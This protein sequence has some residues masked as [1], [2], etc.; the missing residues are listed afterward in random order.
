MIRFSFCLLLLFLSLACFSQTQDT[1]KG[2]VPS[3]SE[4]AIGKARVQ[5]S[6]YSPAVR[7]RVIWGGLVPYDQVWVTGAHSA[8]A[9]EFGVNV[10]INGQEIKAGK[11]ALFTIPSKSEWTI[12]INKNYEQHLADD[13]SEKDD[14]IRLKVPVQESTHRE[15]LRYY[16]LKQDESTVE[17]SIGWEKKWKNIFSS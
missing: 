15:R 16:L 5:V 1:T 6:Y 14:V 11:Y 9:I 13:Y 12:I 10:Q 3:I 4:V 17:L 2:S 7:G 8:T